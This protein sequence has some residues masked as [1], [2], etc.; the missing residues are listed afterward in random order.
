MVE[1]AFELLFV[2]SLVTPTV[3]IILGTLLVIGPPRLHL[4]LTTRPAPRRPCEAITAASQVEA[5]FHQLVALVVGDGES[6][7]FADELHGAVVHS[8]AGDD[9]RELL[10]APD[11]HEPA[12]ELGAEPWP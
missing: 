7:A 6:D 1:R 10:V 12:Q 8:D 9:A 3:T 2:L 4:V 5:R 11:L